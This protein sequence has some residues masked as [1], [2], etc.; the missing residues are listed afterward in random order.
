MTKLSEKADVVVVGGGVIGLTIARALALRGVNNILLIERARL[1]S[2]ASAAA[3]GMIGPQ[4]EAD[5]VD[6]FFDLC[7]QSRDMYPTF[8]AALREETGI[9]CE[10][11]RTGTLYLAFSEH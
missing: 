9:D 2:E 1:G 8:A 3:A 7:C 5:C 6:Q 10:L 4:T 11:D